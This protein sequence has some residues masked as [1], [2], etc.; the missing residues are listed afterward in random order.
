[1]VVVQAVAGSSPVAHL[2]ALQTELFSRG[3]EASAECASAL[4]VS[5]LGR[6]AGGHKPRFVS[7]HDGLDAIAEP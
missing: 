6:L 2:K 4:L 3:E 1:M 5:G 7:E